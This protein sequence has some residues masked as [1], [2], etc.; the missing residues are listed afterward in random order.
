MLLTVELV[1]HV[2][3]HR[4]APAV[5]RILA[6][7]AVATIAACVGYRY[8]YQHDLAGS[9]RQADDLTNHAWI[10]AVRVSRRNEWRWR[11]DGQSTASVNIRVDL[12][13]R[14]AIVP[15]VAKACLLL[16]RPC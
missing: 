7:A 4:R 1:S 16:Q 13:G 6:T 9:I 15:A 10:P 5:V 11:T 12:G 2:Q 14:H 8:S 3:V